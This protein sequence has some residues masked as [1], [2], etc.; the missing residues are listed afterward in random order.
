M[1]LCSLAGRFGSD[2]T[3]LAKLAMEHRLA[4]VAPASDE[5]ADAAAGRAFRAITPML[6][7]WLNDE[8]V[9]GTPDEV[10]CA[11]VPAMVTSLAYTVVLNKFSNKAAAVVMA[12]EIKTQVDALWK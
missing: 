7:K 6:V 11:V 3:T 2:R 8:H 1:G 10:A 4:T 9:R 12:D 5:P